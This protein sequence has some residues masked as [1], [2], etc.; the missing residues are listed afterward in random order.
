MIAFT[1]RTG[2]Q[3]LEFI[4]SHKINYGKN[5]L[6][7]MIWQ[8]MGGPSLQRS[9]DLLSQLIERGYL[10]EINVGTSFAIVIVVL[11][12]RGKEAVDNKE[13]IALDLQGFY[14]AASMPATDASI[15]GKDILEEYYHIKKELLGLQK[16]EEE[17]KN[18][19]KLA[20]TEKNTPEIHSDLMD[21]YC[22]KVERIT[23]PKEKIER[24]VPSA[25]L[26]KIRTV[27]ETI[28]LITTLKGVHL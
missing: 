11:T 22:K 21:L 10:K 17:L 14:T 2:L 16:R 13:N 18:T 24:F 4:N 27:H 1:N 9:K 8:E 7:K 28:V 25:I 12:D 15:V 19:I 26:E 5:N 23:Y 20:M 6:S 3:I